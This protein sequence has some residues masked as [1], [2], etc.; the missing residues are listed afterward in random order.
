MRIALCLL[1]CS[2]ACASEAPK[3][4]IMTVKA[5]G[6]CP[7]SICCGKYADGKTATWRDAQKAG[8]AVDPKVIP[9]GSH[10]DIPGCLRH[11]SSIPA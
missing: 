4:I 11:D 10:I 3:P 1:F 8:V 7:C 2:F 9:L 6:Y 5:T